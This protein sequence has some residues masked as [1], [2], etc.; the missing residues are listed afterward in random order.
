MG[1]EK[2]HSSGQL[3]R[4]LFILTNFNV[5]RGNVVI[6]A[7]AGIQCYQ[8]LSGFRVKPGMTGGGI[9]Q[10]SANRQPPFI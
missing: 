8:V 3:D 5:I 9:I 1:R 6:P 10:W 7:K 2:N 4:H